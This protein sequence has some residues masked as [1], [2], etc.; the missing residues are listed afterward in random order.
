MEK[1]GKTNPNAATRTTILE[2]ATRAETQ[3]AKMDKLGKMQS[4]ASGKTTL[5]DED[6]DEEGTSSVPAV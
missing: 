4:D 2:D 3:G 1:L 5:R 6:D